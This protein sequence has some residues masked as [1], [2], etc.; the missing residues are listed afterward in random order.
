MPLTGSAS[1]C[2]ERCEIESSRRAGDTAQLVG[3]R[4]RD[5]DYSE[6]KVSKR[7][8]MKL[9][10]SCR[11]REQASRLGARSNLI[12]E[13]SN[14]SRRP[15]RVDFTLTHIKR[16]GQLRSAYHPIE[17]LHRSRICNIL[18]SANHSDRPCGA[19]SDQPSFRHTLSL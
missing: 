19:F 15:D 13:K 8:E 1:W 11:S 14:T 5:F 16:V 17:H 3:C 9:S 18:P 4:S 12:S 6:G 7:M 10:R 2:S